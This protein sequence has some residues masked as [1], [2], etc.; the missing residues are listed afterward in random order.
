MRK[1]E[2]QLTMRMTFLLAILGLCATGCAPVTLTSGSAL[3]DATRQARAD[4]AAALAASP[5]DAAVTTGARLI[6]QIDAG[7]K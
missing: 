3:C 6:R 2:R 1:H 7:C 4:H 5:D